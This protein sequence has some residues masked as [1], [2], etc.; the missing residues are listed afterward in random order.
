MAA[1]ATRLLACAVL[2]IAIIAAASACG[3]DGES[4][5]PRARR[6]TLR[7]ELTVDGEPFDS[8]F[9]GARVRQDGLVAPC[10]VVLSGV[11]DGEYDIDV[12]PDSEVRGC[13]ASGT[14]IFLWTVV[15]DE[16]LYSLVEFNWPEDGA[17]A[18][19]DATFSTSTPQGVAPAMTDFRGRVTDGSG[20][21]VAPGD[22]VEAYVGDVLCG[23]APIREDEGFFLTVVG[24]DGVEGCES[25]AT[26]TFRVGAAQAR[27]TAINEPTRSG[28]LDLTLP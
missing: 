15:D 21:P 12:F 20:Q 23:L 27:E 7:G 9:L 26:L 22:L 18:E 5:D 17:T 13:G 24:P 14:R 25:G 11:T 4:G 8:R 28:R 19:F 3:S 10:Q 1:R 6:V 16:Q 2:L